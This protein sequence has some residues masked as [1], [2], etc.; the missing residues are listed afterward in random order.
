MSSLDFKDWKSVGWT[1]VSKNL[2]SLVI[3]TL[4]GPPNDLPS[5]KS[6][7]FVCCDRELNW[8]LQF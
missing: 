3:K 1:G 5:K 8:K 7:G 6:G 2:E 4:S